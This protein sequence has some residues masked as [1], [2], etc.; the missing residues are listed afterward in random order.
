MI[1]VFFYREATTDSVA[2]PLDQGVYYR[3]TAAYR[4]CIKMLYLMLR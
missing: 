4:I 2:N 1:N 3:G